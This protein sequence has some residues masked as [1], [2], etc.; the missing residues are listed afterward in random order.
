M[1]LFLDLL[2]TLKIEGERESAV[3]ICPEVQVAAAKAL[4]NRTILDLCGAYKRLSVRGLLPSRNDDVRF[5]ISDG[6]PGALSQKS[7]SEA[8]NTITHPRDIVSLLGV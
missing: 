4:Q 7:G 8:D 1:A 6:T 3:S 2:H 5:H